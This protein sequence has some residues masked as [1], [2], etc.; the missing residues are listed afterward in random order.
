MSDAFDFEIGVA[1][2]PDFATSRVAFESQNLKVKTKV[3]DVGQSL[4]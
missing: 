3:N 4:P 1:K 2:G